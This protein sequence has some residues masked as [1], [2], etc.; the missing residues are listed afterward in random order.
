[1]FILLSFPVRMYS[2]FGGVRLMLFDCLLFWEL[3]M[4]NPVSKQINERESF[5]T[6]MFS[7]AVISDK[8]S[9]SIL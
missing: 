6:D 2:K 5:S 7:D 9:A 3:C 4:I 1:M 8:L